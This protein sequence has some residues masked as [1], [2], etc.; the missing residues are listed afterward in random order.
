MDGKR[1]KRTFTCKEDVWDVVDILVEEARHFN[2]TQGKEFDISSSVM[3]QIP[4]F[5]CPNFFFDSKVNRDIERY[6]YCEKFG[7]PPF[8]GSYGEQP[9]SWVERAFAIRK[10]LAKKEQSQMQA[11]KK[12]QN[13]NGTTT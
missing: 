2:E 3:S 9:H 13:N 5:A 6:L 7:T 1:E 12:R 8:K 4:F 11:M 10:A